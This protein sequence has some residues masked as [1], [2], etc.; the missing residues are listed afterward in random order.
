MPIV[1]KR[2]VVALANV[3]IAML[4]L[5]L[6]SSRVNASCDPSGD[7]R[8][9]PARITESNPGIGVTA[10]PSALTHNTRAALPPLAETSSPVA[11]SAAFHAPTDITLASCMAR[12]AVGSNA[13]LN[14]A[15]S[16]IAM[17]TSCPAAYPSGRPTMLEFT[18]SPFAS[19]GT[20]TSRLKRHP[21]RSRG[22]RGERDA[23]VGHHRLPL[24]EQ[25]V[26]GLDVAVDHALAMRVIERARD[27][28]REPHRVVDR[29]LLLA[30]QPIA[31]RVALHEGHH[32]EHRALHFAPP[33][34]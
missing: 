23:E 31:Q 4:A 18:T 6:P 5:R 2:L 16:P 34:W 21:V 26:L 13:T 33:R 9:S 29:Q 11:L 19:E 3:Y 7:S 8:G 1:A 22:R 28:A 17:Y 14:K 10:R 20:L 32:M 25:D 30:V 12:A 15:S 27:L 24:V